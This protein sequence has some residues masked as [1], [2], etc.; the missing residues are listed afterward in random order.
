MVA[1]RRL[2]LGIAR[3]WRRED[4]LAKKRKPVKIPEE[5]KA[6]REKLIQELEQAADDPEL[7]ARAEECHKEISS[8]SAEDLLRPFNI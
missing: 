2:N 3:Q 6:K 7:R 4:Q 5:L 8:L 1:P